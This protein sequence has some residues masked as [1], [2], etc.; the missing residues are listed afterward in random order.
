MLSPLA[1]H[2]KGYLQPGT[3]NPL[4]G[5][6]CSIKTAWHKLDQIFKECTPAQMAMIKSQVTL[7]CVFDNW[8]RLINKLWQDMGKSSIFQ[9]GTA[10]FFKRD[11]TF[12]L[13]PGTMMMSPT[14]MQFS[15]VSCIRVDE[16]TCTIIGE[17]V[18]FPLT[19]RAN[20]RFDDAMEEVQTVLVDGLQW[21]YLGW[22]VTS[23]LGHKKCKDITY[24]VNQ[25]IPAPIGMRVPLES[26]SDD[27]LFEARL[28]TND[29]REGTH[30]M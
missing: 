26:S 11:K 15:V 16:Y 4:I 2:C 24:G 9:R 30:Q 21:P 12:T 8:Q 17:I 10:F 18:P 19:R 29:Q 7:T 5:A 28:F 1:H 22:I 23:L 13:P 3:K 14:G 27:I 20:E 6:G 25:F